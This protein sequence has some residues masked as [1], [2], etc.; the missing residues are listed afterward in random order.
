MFPCMLTVFSPDTCRR[1]N[2]SLGEKKKPQDHKGV[3]EPLHCSSLVTRIQCGVMQ[4]PKIMIPMADC[5]RTWHVAGRI[6]EDD[7]KW[8]AGSHMIAPELSVLTCITSGHCLVPSER[9]TC[10]T[11]AFLVH[12]TFLVNGALSLSLS[13]P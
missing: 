5:K 8:Y 6:C 12:N 1:L 10:N 11:T 2:K 13:P 9:C 7:G 3:S 4:N